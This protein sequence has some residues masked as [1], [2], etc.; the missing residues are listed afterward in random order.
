MIKPEDRRFIE[1][2]SDQRKGSKV[3]Y[4]AIYTIAWGV[5]IFLIIFFLTRLFTSLWN[6]G[7]QYLALLFIAISLVASV[8]ITHYIWTNNEKRLHRL[9]KEHPEMFN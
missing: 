3:G 6:T 4:Y 7:G 8:I 9:M 2:W 1:Q 5:I